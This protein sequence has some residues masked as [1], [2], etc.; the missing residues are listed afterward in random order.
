MN[1]LVIG[2][3]GREHALVWKLSQS[4]NVKKIYCA[5]GNAGIAQL[6]EC[7]PVAAEDIRGLLEFAKDNAVDL[8]VVGPEAPLVAGIVDRFESA[9]LKAF[10]PRA[11]AAIMEG[12]KAFSKD[13]MKRYRIPT[14]GYEVFTDHAKAVAYLEKA[15]V[16][17]VIKAD[18]LA[19]GKGA[20]VCMDLDS[21]RRALREVMVDRVFKEAGDRVVIEEF[22][23]GEEASIL[24]FTDSK[25]IIPMASAQDHKR[26]Y[27]NDEGPNTGGMGAYSPAPVM[28]DALSKRVYDEILQPTVRAM[29]KEGR[30]YKGMLYAGLMITKDGPKVVEFNCRF[31]DPETQAVLPRMDGD[32]AEV[33]LACIEERLDGIHFGWKAGSAVCVVMAS[34]GYPGH[35]EKGKVITGLDAFRET[36]SV[37]VFHAG[38]KTGHEGTIVTSG[39]RVLGVTALG[40][41]VK[42]AIRT[43]YKAVSTIQF[44]GGFYRRDIGA[45]A[46]T[47]R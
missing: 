1:I 34:G 47:R 37:I 3:G 40:K 13:L 11:N 32:L 44:D 43:A 26:A 16:P 36:R 15:G 39:G 35:Y 2:S 10:G 7:V 19:A 28:T 41:D 46:L 25:T 24:A 27:D 29:T 5:P 38:T 42:S 9:G 33:M 31:G 4:K 20:I 14:A 18:G 12:S 8:T 23:V 30:P 6:A 17:I 21:A 45:R 22:L